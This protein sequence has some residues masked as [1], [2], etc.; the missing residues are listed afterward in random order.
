MYISSH[1]PLHYSCLACKG[2]RGSMCIH[3]CN[4]CEP[5]QVYNQFLYFGVLSNVSYNML[6]QKGHTNTCLGPGRIFIWLG[7]TRPTPPS[8]HGLLVHTCLGTHLCWE[9]VW[10]YAVKIIHIQVDI[11][12][13]IPKLIDGVPSRAKGA[14]WLKW[15]G[16]ITLVP[17]EDEFP[18]RCGQE[19]LAVK[20]A[21]E[22]WGPAE[23][24][25]D[26]ARGQIHSLSHWWSKLSSLYLKI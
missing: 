9:P 21:W 13:I 7:P 6:C 23:W 10:R 4:I 11:T 12:F 26:L 15:L 18:S 24:R 19:D 3:V 17:N 8:L 25:C 22:G 16:I 14:W 5:Y 1:P 20:K 2:P